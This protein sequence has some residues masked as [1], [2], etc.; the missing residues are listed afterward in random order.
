MPLKSLSHV[1][2]EDKVPGWMNSTLILIKLKVQNHCVKW[3]EVFPVVKASILLYFHVVL[4]ICLK[5]FLV[6]IHECEWTMREGNNVGIYLLSKWKSTRMGKAH[7][8]QLRTQ[9]V[10]RWSFI[11]LNL[12]SHQ[13]QVQFHNS[14]SRCNPSKLQVAFQIGCQ[15]LHIFLSFHALPL[16]HSLPQ[17]PRV[18][19]TL[20]WNRALS[21]WRQPATARNC[22]ITLNSTVGPGH[23][24]ASCKGG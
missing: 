4:V 8:F 10:G 22:Q 12:F 24:N 13:P 5:S 15:D 23:L 16:S 21:G 18:V 2:A 6:T 14:K 3:V 9:S 20:S 11:T 19:V 7:C 1:S 17:A